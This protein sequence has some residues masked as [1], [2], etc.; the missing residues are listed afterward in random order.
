MIDLPAAAEKVHTMIHEARG[1]GEGFA[2]V[3]EALGVDP[4][5]IDALVTDRVAKLNGDSTL[6]GALMNG[7]LIGLAAERPEGIDWSWIGQA[8]MHPTRRA[9]LTYLTN[10][11]IGSP[12]EISQFTGEP[13]GNV[14]YHVKELF[15]PRNRE[16]NPSLIELTKTEPR[17]GAVEHFYRRRSKPVMLKKGQQP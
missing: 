11:G 2:A 1:A 10:H 6:D 9:I 16:K 5:E 13:L 4:K 12:N 15:D 14:S 17:R 7:L 3:C 8:G